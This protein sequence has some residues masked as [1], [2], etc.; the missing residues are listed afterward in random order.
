MTEDEKF[1]AEAVK[2]AEKG[3]GEGEVPIG[4]IA[5]RNGIIIARGHN[6][7]YALSDITAHAEMI[8]LRD[9]SSRELEFNLSDV[10]IY[11]TLEPCAMCTGAMIH[12]KVGRVVFGEY[13][14]VAGACGTKYHFHE[15]AGLKVTGG[16]FRRESR[17]PLLDF[18]EKQL[19]RKSFNWK[20]IQL[21]P[22]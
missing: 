20:D 21:P 8:C 13:D 14:I 15:A 11:S 1:M 22:E 7:R 6:R 9:L 4:A 2:E 18:F 16:I 10:T 3:F 17:K 19:D 5:V 12:Y